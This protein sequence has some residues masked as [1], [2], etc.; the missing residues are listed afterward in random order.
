MIGT[1]VTIKNIASNEDLLVYLLSVA[2]RI[3]FQKRLNERQDNV[4]M[5][6]AK[7]IVL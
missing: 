5:P 6:K 7:S 3:A 4:L 2:E 1:Q